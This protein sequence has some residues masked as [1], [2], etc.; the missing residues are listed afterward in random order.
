MKKATFI[1]Q[2]LTVMAV[3]AGMAG[4]AS[5]GKLQQELIQE[6][7]LEQVLKRGVRSHDTEVIKRGGDP[8]QA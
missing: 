2:M 8:G 4:W 3:V 5:A 6:S 7:T 1:L